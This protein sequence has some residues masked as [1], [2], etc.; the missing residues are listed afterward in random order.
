MNMVDRHKVEGTTPAITI[1][2]RIFRDR[3]GNLIISAVWQAEYWLGGRQR[4]KS[5]GT[6]NK[7]DAIR[8]AICLSRKLQDNPDQHQAPKRL[9]IAVACASYIEMQENQGRAPKTLEKYRCVLKAF[10][11]WVKDQRYA[12]MSA[13]KEQDFWAYRK[14]MSRK[15][16][17]EATQADHLI[18]IKQV[19]K[20]AAGRARLIPS[21]PISQ[22]V[23]REPESQPQPC[24]TPEQVDALLNAA[25]LHYAPIYAF[26]AYAGLRFG[27]V[28]ALRWQDIL[29]D[30]GKYGVIIVRLG[31]S[32]DTTKGRRSRAIPI[33]AHLRTVIDSLPRNNE[34]VFSGR[35]KD[36]SP[37]EKPLDEKRVI[38]DLKK[39]CKKL[40]FPNPNQYK[41]HTFRHSFASMCAR[42]NLSH[43]YALQFMGHKNSDILDLYYTMFDS[44][45]EAAIET[46]SYGKEEPQ[47]VVTAAKTDVV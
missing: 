47:V 13:F 34:R 1:G 30:R 46:I 25:D 21:N 40:N 27:E 5:L 38:G 44:T 2:H 42:S 4:S 15:G 8:Q 31:G 41:I 7:A 29:L 3:G 10:S 26:L 28:R 24:F 45:A 12:S 19:F 43:K 14:Y 22:V 16:K 18:L 20:W 6:T 32:G 11:E 36:G 23:V 35:A 37:N 39:L 17:S 9:A 33:N